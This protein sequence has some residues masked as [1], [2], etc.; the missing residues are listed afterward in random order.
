MSGKCSGASGETVVVMGFKHSGA[1]PG[2]VPAC[3]GKDG[4]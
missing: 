3:L 4:T 2:P 1:M